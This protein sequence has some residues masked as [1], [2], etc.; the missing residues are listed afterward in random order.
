MLTG[1]GDPKK[2]EEEEELVDLLTTV[3]EHC[4]QLE[5]CVKAREQLVLCESMCLPGHRQKRIVQRSSLTS[6]M[7]GTTVWPT[8]SSKA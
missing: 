7:H 5:K 2:E 4:E 6:C 1:A 8:N 3:K